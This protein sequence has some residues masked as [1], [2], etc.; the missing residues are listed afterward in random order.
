MKKE[1]LKA[2][3][4]NKTV[5]I[6]LVALAAL[7]LLLAVWKVFFSTETKKPSAYQPTAQ[8]E[9][10]EQLL[11]QIEGVRNATVMISVADDETVGAVVVFEGADSI[12]TRIRVIEVASNALNLSKERILVY[13]S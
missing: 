9:R 2:F 3:F 6:L 8:E 5:R 4:Q 7:L 12:L 11:S 13:P 1:N 10:L